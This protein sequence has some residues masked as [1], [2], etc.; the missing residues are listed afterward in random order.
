MHYGCLYT[1]TWHTK[2]GGF[3]VL[4]Q[5]SWGFGGAVLGFELRLLYLLSKHLSHVSIPSYFIYFS[6]ISTWV[7]L[8]VQSSYL[9]S[10]VVVFTDVPHHIQFVC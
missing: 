3:I 5:M 1:N 4:C 6:D 9:H 2:I 7:S 8:R 10:H